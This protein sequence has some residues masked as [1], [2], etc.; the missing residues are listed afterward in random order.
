MVND[1][2]RLTN[3]ATAKAHLG[4][5]DGPVLQMPNGVPN[6]EGQA[7]MDK[8]D[9]ADAKIVS[10]AHSWGLEYLVSSHRADVISSL[11][12]V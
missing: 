8:L 7:V 3:Q 4:K 10:V 9:Q 6:I 11:I 2:A 5:A 1:A 12:G